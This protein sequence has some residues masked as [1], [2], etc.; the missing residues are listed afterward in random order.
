MTENLL[1]ERKIT[2][3]IDEVASKNPAPGGGSV[4]ALSGALG[5]SLVAMV[6][7]LTVGKEKYKDV[8]EEI[9]KILEQ[10]KEHQ[11]K[12]LALVDEDAKVYEGVVEAFKLP[13]STDEEIKTRDDAI[14]NALKKA[15]SVPLECANECHKIMDFAK[16]VAE[17]GNV[18]AI[19]D[20]GVAAA[21][22][23]SGIFGAALNV[24]INLFSIKDETF[25]KE[26]EEELNRIL[27]ASKDTINEIFKCSL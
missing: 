26:K 16:F 9:K 13:K 3:F 12:L 2:E 11:N 6:C 17:K 21:M 25:K 10:S 23:N 4:A 19:T 7:Q 18:N 14:Q 15:A 24:K 27:L 22:A 20:S 8:N 5:A 1:V